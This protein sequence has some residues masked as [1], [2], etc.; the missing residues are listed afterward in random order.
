MDSNQRA[1]A[2]MS[3]IG[4][5]YAELASPSPESESV[6]ASSLAERQPAVSPTK[7]ATSLF[8]S[9]VR[10][11]SVERLLPRKTKAMPGRPEPLRELPD[12]MSVDA[13]NFLNRGLPKKSSTSSMREADGDSP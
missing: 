5:G 9:T 2:R 3:K 12:V 7:R 10:I 1:V 6:V 13:A 11:R 4:I 8:L